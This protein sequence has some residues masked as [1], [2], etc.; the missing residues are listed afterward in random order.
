MS[1][2][3]A[4]IEKKW[5]AYWEKHASFRT[6]E[7]DKT[8]PKYYILD[9][10]PYPS[11]AGLHVGHPEG[12]TA[13]DIVTR[14]KRMCGFSVLHPMGWDA[15]GL[16]AERYAM[17]TGID[18]AI[19]TKQNI[20]NFRRQLKS[21]GFSYDWEREI[22]TTDPAYYRWTQWIFLKIFNSF[23]DEKQKKARPISELKIPNELS[24][25]PDKAKEYIDSKRLAYVSQAPVNWCAKL[26]AVLANE[27]VEEWTSKGYTVE[28]RLMSQWMLRITAYGERLLEDL[29][30]VDWPTSTLEL[31]KNWIGRSQGALIRFPIAKPNPNKKDEGQKDQ[32]QGK[33]ESEG[34][35]EVY[36]TRPDTIFGVTYMVLAPEHPL[37]RK[38]FCHSEEYRKEVDRYV[39]ASARHSELERMKTAKTGCFTGGYV[40]HPLTKEKIPVWIADYVLMNYGTGAIMAV[41]AHDERDFV[42]ASKFSLDIRPV[43][44]GVT[45][46]PTSSRGKLTEA[47]TRPGININS[48]FLDGLST[49]EAIPKMI[50]ELERRKLGQAKVNYKLRDWLFSRQRYWGEPIPI[51]QDEAGNY[52]C[53]QEEDLPLV[54]PEVENFQPAPTGESP[55]ALASSWLYHQEAGVSGQKLRRESNTMPQWAGSCW[56]YL[57]FIDPDNQDA[58]VNTDKEAYWM[59][60]SGVDLYIGGAEHAVLHLLYSRFWHKVLYDLGY[61]STSEPF[62]KL[63]H[64]GLI[65]GEDGNKMSKS[66][67]NVI[68][69][70]SVIKEYGADAFRLFEMF[71]GPLE[72]N[73]PWSAKGIEG[74]SRFL[75][76]VWRLYV[77][78]QAQDNGTQGSE[79]TTG[80]TIDPLLLKEPKVEDLGKRDYLLHSTIQKVSEDIENLAFNTAIAC[81][82]SF[83]NE[84][85]THK[86][87]GRFAAEAFVL[88]LGPFAPHLAE[89]LWVL[90][91]HQAGL[92]YASWP[93][94]DATKTKTKE[95]EVV[96]QVNSKLRAKTK[97]AW[98]TNEKSLEKLAQANTNV[99]RFIEGK[100]I[101][102]TIVVK[103]KLVNIVCKG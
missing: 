92:V 20:D 56:Y 21:L 73:K 43:I 47:Y 57:R 53:T 3:F 32:E 70:D 35:L 99:Q 61:V 50:A 9:M 27:E 13:T 74:C 59:A 6:P 5:Q 7:V 4:N 40:Y 36:T 39:R 102:R 45:K 48:D 33:E 41:P 38:V 46:N 30:L 88:L 94:Y 82:M 55:L 77:L 68:S 16:P 51:S 10:F 86:H 26:A 75:N 67:G 14:Y 37:V 96:F 71:L 62:Y 101:I 1:Y 58:F 66:L 54:L 11:G 2:P 95:V 85:Y 12:Y 18:P 87:I 49:K 78:E 84:V 28:R 24:L 83:V 22:N 29:K 15:F 72:Q 25:S 34:V 19:T 93:Q 76:R 98:D 89:E 52:Y 23:Y 103:N 44:Q 42:F 64:Q 80:A 90:L 31:Q 69:P 17:Q 8:K 60:S 65:L 79:A 91:G 63:V 97:V 100:Q 81:L